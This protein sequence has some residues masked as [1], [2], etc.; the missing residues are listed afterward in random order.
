MSPMSPM[1]RLSL[2]TLAAA[3]ALAG[4][5]NPPQGRVDVA[6]QPTLPTAWQ[7]PWPQQTAAAPA[8][9]TGWTR[10]NDPLLP[11]LI[12][13]AQASSPTLAS[14]AARIERARATR[15]AAAAALLPS[16]DAVAGASQTRTLPRGGPTS[17]ATLGV[18]AGWEIDL[19]GGA[20]AGRDAAQARL[21]AAQ[22]G[23]AAAQ[24]AVAAET[25]SS[26]VAL[27]ACEAQRDQSRLDAD[28]RAETARLSELSAKAGFTAPADAALARAS[29][30]QART[31]AVSQR[32][33]CDTL[34][35]A[36]VELTAVAE[37][38]L[39]PRLAARSAVVPTPDALS[40]SDV[41]PATLLARRPDLAEA[42][43][44]V[45]AA[46]GDR[47][48]ARARER[49]QVTLAGS[50][51]ELAGRSSGITATGPVW[52]LGPLQVTLPLFDAGARAA[53][54]AAA[55]ASYDEAVAQYQ[56]LARRAVREVE[57]SLVALQAAVQR[58]ADAQSAARDFEVSLRATEA[59]QKGGLASLFDLEA[60]RRNAVAARIALVDLQRER[61]AAWISLYR[62]LG[63]GWDA[64]TTMPTTMP[65]ATSTATPTATSTAASI[66][67]QAALR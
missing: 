29:A 42:E 48:Q 7:A 15:T 18:Q 34:V 23:Q 4:C 45:V 3:A 54:T 14:A 32:A 58:E 9:A 47:T 40:S 2:P 60:A 59:R 66:T 36:L 17:S 5:A 27:R 46:A 26:Y 51:S 50:L 52:S 55:Q 25:A 35:K 10:F 56:G 63:G 12:E 61:A 11:A 22:A 38:E 24:L 64:S 21:Q 44:N 30:A 20:A 41:L 57:S 8:R 16:V 39:R 31:V 1:S 53:A 67:Q 33:A 37:P 43:R 13:A 19:F 49:P 65:T 28:S 6:T 62:A